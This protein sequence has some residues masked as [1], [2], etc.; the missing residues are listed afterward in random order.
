MPRT[1]Y[2]DLIFGGRAV[3]KRILVE[4]L[5]IRRREKN[6]TQSELDGILELGPEWPTIKE[7]EDDP[8]LLTEA[9]IYEAEH[10]LNVEPKRWEDSC[11]VYGTIIRMRVKEYLVH[12]IDILNRALGEFRVSTMYRQ[13]ISHSG[14]VYLSGIA[15]L[16]I[17]PIRE[18]YENSALA[19]Q[20]AEEHVFGCIMA[21]LTPE[22]LGF[23]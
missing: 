5:V 11:L 22:D 23:N 2:A 10:V 18:T 19:Q 1:A 6:V 8:N 3:V 12:H 9:F 20:W 21:E 13:I 16:A 7:V 14:D 4:E 17:K 15:A